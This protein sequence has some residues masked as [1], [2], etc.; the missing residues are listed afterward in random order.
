MSG[1]PLSAAAGLDNLDGDQIKSVSLR[2]PY[3][4]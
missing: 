3:N 2:H 1:V 4:T